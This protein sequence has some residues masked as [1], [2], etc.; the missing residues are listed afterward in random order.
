MKKARRKPVTRAMS[1]SKPLDARLRGR[2]DGLVDHYVRNRSLFEQLVEH[3]KTLITNNA[4][5][6]KYVHSVK[7]RVKDPDHLRDKLE[8]K[9]REQAAQGKPFPY[10]PENLFTKV[11]DL[12]GFR[13]L[14]LHTRQMGEINQ[15]LEA[16]FKEDKYLV[17]EGP[18]ARTW[19]D[20]SRSY[21]GSIGIKTVKSAS[22]Y[23]S[24]HY[25]LQPNRRT[26]ITCELQ[27]RTLM[28]EVWGEVAHSINYPHPTDSVSCQEQIAVLAR[29][30]SACTRLVDSVFSSH[31]DART[32][33]GRSNSRR[34]R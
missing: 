30:T 23:T 2:I 15:C 25:V 34:R 24:V 31:R 9:A 16:L 22:L 12:A 27:V 11:N 4:S 33:A 32:P 7:W 8:R 5:L 21:F 20:E 28:E 19:D 14:H 17:V 13:I 3:L 18:A 10:T 1:V 29:L 26:K 6:K